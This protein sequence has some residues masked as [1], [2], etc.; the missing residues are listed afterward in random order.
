LCAFMQAEK[1][2]VAA[3]VPT[4]WIGVL[5]HAA[6][7]SAALSSLRTLICGGSA[8]PRSMIE[9]FETRFG[10]RVIQGWGMTET[11]P[12]AALA[13]PPADVPKPEQLEWR[14]MT[15]R[16]IA[17]VELRI[18]DSDGRAQPWNGSAVGEIEVRGPWVTAEY[19]REPSPERFHDGWLR[20]GDV[21]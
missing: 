17:G 16:V 13:R 12:L 6:G 2:T 7:N 10:V 21:G 8:V 3:G 18:T 11:S 15:G 14:A 19:Y 9:Q 5:N 20:T 1:P 4:V